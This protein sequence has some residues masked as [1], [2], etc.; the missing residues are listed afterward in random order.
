MKVQKYGFAHHF[1]ASLA[2][3][4][5]R[6]SMLHADSTRRVSQDHA[7]FGRL[8]LTRGANPLEAVVS[9]Y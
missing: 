9:I 3:S 5:L 7:S 2:A 8:L 1:R 4:A 6:P